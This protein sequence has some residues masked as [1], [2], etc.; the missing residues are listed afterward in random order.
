MKPMECKKF[1]YLIDIF[2][3]I[4]GNYFF[5]LFQKESIQSTFATNTEVSRKKKYRHFPPA[6]THLPSKFAFV[7]KKDT[8]SKLEYLYIKDKTKP[9]S[10][11]IRWFSTQHAN[12]Y[13]LRYG[14]NPAN[15]LFKFV[16]LLT[17]VSL[18]ASD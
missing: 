17:S 16:S 4:E 6:R 1:S 12:V 14:N 8:S 13:I 18:A 2:L 9:I 5:F 7:Y 3:A 11:E 15:V 10:I